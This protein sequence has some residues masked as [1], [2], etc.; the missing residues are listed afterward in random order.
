LKDL[1]GSIGGIEGGLG[2]EARCVLVISNNL[3]L[4]LTSLTPERSILL[5]GNCSAVVTGAYGFTA[6]KIAANALLTQGM[7]ATISVCDLRTEVYTIKALV[8][9]K[10]IAQIFLVK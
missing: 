5:K 3:L 10:T 2:F 7:S 4:Q 8:E 9:G 6:Q 1:E